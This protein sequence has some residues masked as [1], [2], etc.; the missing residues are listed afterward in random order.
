MASKVKFA[1]GL[2]RFTKVF[3]IF[4]SSYCRNRLLTDILDSAFSLF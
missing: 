2:V 1:Q 4:A 3:N